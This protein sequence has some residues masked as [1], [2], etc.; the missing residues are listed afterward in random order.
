MHIRYALW[1]VLLV[2]AAS[3]A[4]AEESCGMRAVGLLADGKTKELAALFANQSE[5]VEPLQRMVESLG[6]V[7]SVQEESTARFA[8]HKRISIQ[9]KDLPPS[10][11]YQGYW[12][13]ARSETLGALQ[14][15]IARAPESA[16]GLLAL[17]MDT[18]Q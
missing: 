14:F 6:K 4:A 7:T 10:Y 13:N 15:H 1:P 3:G 2:A 9:S 12:I 5:V 8:Q 17:H 11:K 18:A 16:C